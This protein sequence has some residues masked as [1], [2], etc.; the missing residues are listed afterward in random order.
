MSPSD[1]HLMFNVCDPVI[2]PS[3]R[4]D[5]GGT[6]PVADVVQTGIV[7]SALLCLPNIKD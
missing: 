7:G 2:C 3:S 4:C 1:C 5:F 6:Y